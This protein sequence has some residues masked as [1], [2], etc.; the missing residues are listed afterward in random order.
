MSG[1]EDAISRVPLFSQLSGKERKELAGSMKERTFSAGSVITDVG[2]GA[3]GFF[4]IDDGTAT[5]EAGGDKR[6]VLKGGDYFGEIAL[7]D[8]GTRTAKITA[9]S[10]LHCY[11]MTSWE[12]RP[13]VQTHPDV[14]W[15]LL[16]TLAQRVREAEGRKDG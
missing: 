14:A 8:E 16:Q 12:F 9:D 5:V 15:A 1:V 3:V 2:Q 6:R 13:F 7:I 4:I 10:D 11:G